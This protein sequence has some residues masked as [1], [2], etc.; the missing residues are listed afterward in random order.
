MMKKAS[1]GFTLI[2]LMIV[3]AIIGILAA[4]AIPNF[5]RYQ[6]R[7]KVSELS[8]N[9]NSIF[10]SEEA[11]RQSER[12]NPAQKVGQ[13]WA[14]GKLPAG[15]APLS[16][17]LDWAGTDVQLAR[18]IDWAI[19]GSTYGVYNTGAGSSSA[20]ANNESDISLTVYAESD[21]DGDTI[22]RCVTLFKPT[23]GSDGTVS[24]AGGMAAANAPCTAAAVTAA[25]PWATPRPAD[26]SVF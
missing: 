2:E 3:V 26:E 20:F 15:K 8:E 21:V 23:L 7:A 12:A 17:K 11:M 9:V 16:T 6:L 1:K 22:F 10:K 4:I 5:M 14:F 13:Y 24:G 25:A 19:E 18:K